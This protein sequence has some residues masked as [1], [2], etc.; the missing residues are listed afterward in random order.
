MKLKESLLLFISIFIFMSCNTN[1]T[2]EDPEKSYPGIINVSGESKPID[3]TYVDERLSIYVP[4]EL[5]TDLTHLSDNERKIVDILWEVADIMEDLFWQQTIGQRDNFLKS[6]SDENTRKLVEINYGPWD[7]LNNNKSFIQTIET[8]PQGAN[9]YPLD[10]TKEEF[11][12]FECPNKTS[13]YT[14]IRRDEQGNLQSVWY[15]EAY[16]V[17]LQKASDLLKK[18]A[19]F[20]D[21]EGLKRYLELR[22]QALIT[23]DYQASD[24]AWMEMQNANIDFVVGPIENYEDALFG[25]KCAFESFILV[26]D[27]DWSAKLAKF[28]AMLPQL[29]SEL[30]VSEEYKKDVPGSDSDMNVY[31]V[32]YY[33]G[34]CN[35]G[36]KTIAINLP[37]DEEVHKQFG[38][39][40]LQLKNSMKAK[41]DNILYPIAELILD[42]SQMKH[43]KFDA[44]FENVTFHEVAHAMGVKSTINGEQTVREALK[45]QYSSIEEAKADIM[46]LYLVSELYKKGEITSGELMDNFVTFFVGIFR[47]SRFGAASAHGKANM[48]RFNYFEQTGAFTRDAQTGKYTV[49]FDK[50]YDAMISSVQQILTLQGDGNYEATKKLIETEGIVKPTLQQD[51]DLINASNIPVDIVFIQGKDKQ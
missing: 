40:K 44:F 4:F 34:D 27:L 5:K 48:M 11:E 47:S 12:N 38:S 25:Y 50:M 23:S 19:T 32:I 16:R 10:M 1:K 36:S 42:D 15:H 41:F 46:G 45:E 7:R 21:D 28:S 31:D 39:R 2:S 20:A 37:N 43:V 17:S 8:K 22:A 51:L 14:L 33:R 9:F 6:I 29:Q 18:A 30:P 49:N 24:F 13:G 26:K 3:Q 35:A